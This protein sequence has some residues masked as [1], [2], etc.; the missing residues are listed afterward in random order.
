MKWSLI[1]ITLFILLSCKDREIAQQDRSSETNWEL[2]PTPLFSDELRYA[3]VMEPYAKIL[4]VIDHADQLVLTCRRG[5]VLEVHQRKYDE[6]LEHL[7]LQVKLGD[8]SG[9]IPE[10]QV[11][12]FNNREQAETASKE[13]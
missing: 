7:W 1:I 8:S 3:V 4:G 10:Q 12:L 5:D 9:W 6:D 2:A 11:L 13:L